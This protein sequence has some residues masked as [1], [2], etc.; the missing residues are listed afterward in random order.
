LAAFAGLA[1]AAG[2]GLAASGLTALLEMTNLRRTG[3]VL[4]FGTFGALPRLLRDDGF[5]AVTLRFNIKYQTQ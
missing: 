4:T 3:G 2:A 1:G 5:D